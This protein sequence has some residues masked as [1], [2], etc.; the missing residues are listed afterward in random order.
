MELF[1]GGDLLEYK[2]KFETEKKNKRFS[3]HDIA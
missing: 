1:D 2:R 3:E